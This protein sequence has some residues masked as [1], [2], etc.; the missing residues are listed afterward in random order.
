MFGE[1]QKLKV[2]FNKKKS[3]TIIIE[4]IFQL[5]AILSSIIDINVCDNGKIFNFYLPSPLLLWNFS[6]FFRN[7]LSPRIFHNPKTLSTE[8]TININESNFR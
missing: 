4:M 6:P 7:L 8:A 3:L 2:N 5:E 1:C